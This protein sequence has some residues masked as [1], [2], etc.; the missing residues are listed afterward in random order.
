LRVMGNE[1]IF[2]DLWCFAS[3]LPAD[4]T[5]M[6]CCREYARF[7]TF[8][9]DPL[10]GSVGATRDIATGHVGTIKMNGGASP[11]EATGSP[12]PAQPLT[13]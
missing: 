13:C 2:V 1:C 9:V 4:A 6:M 10:G 12:R 8:P 5:R 11:S 3:R 7:L